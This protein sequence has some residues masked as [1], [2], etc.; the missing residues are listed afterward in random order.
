M[1][2]E[3]RKSIVFDN[4]QLERGCCNAVTFEYLAI[5]DELLHISSYFDCMIVSSCLGSD[6]MYSVHKQVYRPDGNLAFCT[7]FRVTKA[8][9][10]VPHLF[11]G[12]MKHQLRLECMECRGRATAHVGTSSDWNVWNVEVGHGSCGNQLRLE[13][14]ECR[15]W[16]TTHVGVSSDWN[17]EGGCG[18]S[19][20][21]SQIKCAVEDCRHHI[22][23]CATEERGRGFDVCGRGFARQNGVIE[24]G[25]G[26]DEVD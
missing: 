16:A 4:F 14:M 5:I 19:S 9:F 23:E 2:L 8:V 17:V 1:Q 22:I 11:Y 7:K 13:C 15:G 24:S 20:K 10:V 25:D 21:R 26:E 6:T 12:N 18:V 3:G